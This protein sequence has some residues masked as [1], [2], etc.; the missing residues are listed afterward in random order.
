MSDAIAIV[1]S[2]GS[3]G[4]FFIAGV[5]ALIGISQSKK[6][7]ADRVYE[8]LELMINYKVE[9]E[10]ALASYAKSPND[11]EIFNNLN[12]RYS[13]FVNYLD[14]FSAKIL[15]QKLYKN[16]AF[17]QFQGETHQGLKDWATIQLGIYEL[18]ERIRF[19][20]FGM[21]SSA[22]TKKSD[23]KNTYILLK[24]VL[25]RKDYKE[26]QDSCRDSGLF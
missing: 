17:K 11:I 20:D 23:L 4:S 21:I 13:A 25:P 16:K 6:K 26:L 24:M 12:T 9:L 1:G 5:I 22:T 15:N 7:D 14:Y 8:Y 2:L 10:F 3:V 18:I 19:N